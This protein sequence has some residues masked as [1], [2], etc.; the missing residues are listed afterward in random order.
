MSA[1]R[2]IDWNRD[3]TSIWENPMFDWKMSVSRRGQP[4]PVYDPWF[5]SLS[6]HYPPKPK[7]KPHHRK[8]KYFDKHHLLALTK[9]LKRDPTTED[10]PEDVIDAA[11][12]I[13]AHNILDEDDGDHTRAQKYLDDEGVKYTIDEQNSNQ[14]IMAV[15]DEVTGDTKAVLRG[16]NIELFKKVVKFLKERFGSGKLEDISPQEIEMAVADQFPKEMKA[17]GKDASRFIEDVEADFH[18]IAGDGR[19]SG[20]YKSVKD[21][22]EAL[23]P[24]N[25]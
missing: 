25:S 23:N 6:H 1:R 19:S 13:K 15:K 8:D 10:I 21:V 16:T 14:H 2:N 24:P 11:K 17:L 12:L 3:P 9:S 20:A 5:E 18:I 4:L 22:I 7:P